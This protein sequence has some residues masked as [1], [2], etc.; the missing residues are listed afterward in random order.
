[1]SCRAFRI[2][3]PVLLVLWVGLSA[4]SGAAAADTA[5]EKIEQGA[6]DLSVFDHWSV[7][8]I[9]FRTRVYADLF[10][11]LDSVEQRV[12]REASDLRKEKTSVV[13]VGD[14]YLRI[15]EKL[16]AAE[17]SEKF[18]QVFT[19]WM[20]SE[21]YVELGQ[22]REARDAANTALKLIPSNP[23]DLAGVCKAFGGVIPLGS[24]TL[25]LSCRNNP[26]GIDF[27]PATVRIRLLAELGLVNALLGDITEAERNI[28]E[29]KKPV[30]ASGVRP[31]AEIARLQTTVPLFALGR[32]EEVASI[33][34]EIQRTSRYKQV[35]GR[36]A[37]KAN[38]SDYFDR[39]LSRGQNLWVN[40]L[41]QLASAV[42]AHLTDAQKFEVGLD[43]ASNSYLYATS[44]AR[45]GRLDE[46]KAV[47]DDMLANPEIQAMGSIYWSVAFERGQIAL[48]QGQR[49]DAIRL[50]RQSIDA[51][52]KVRSSISFEASKIGF[53]G[54]KQAVYAMLVSVLAEAGDWAGAFEVAE[55]AKAR[56]L[57]DLLAEKQDLSPPAV[58][59]EK[60]SQLLAQAV[61][62]DVLP[63][64][65]VEVAQRRDA[66]VAARDQLGKRAPE[67]ASLVSVQNVRLSDI[68]AR[69]GAG[70]T[71][72]SY[73]QA[74]DV[75]YALVVNGASVKGFK[76]AGDG[77]TSEVRRFREELQAG[78]PG[79]IQTAAGLYD[80]LLRPLSGEIKGNAVTVAPHGVLHY[81]PFAALSDGK[82]YLIDSYSLRVMP[83]ASSLVYLKADKPIKQG[84]L[85]ALGNPDLGDARFDLPSAQR[86]ALQVAAMYPSSKA[87]IRQEASK[88]AVREFGN[89]FAILHIA[90][91]GHFDSDSP[92]NSGLL[93]AK[94]R[95]ADGRL[96]VS[97][98][99]S[100]RLDTDLVTLSACETG[101]GKVASGDD[102]VGLTRGFLYAGARTIVSSLW[103]VDDE[104]TAKL[105][106]V[107]YKNL[108]RVGK[109]EALR[110]AQVEIRKTYPHP[111]FW[112]AFQVVGNG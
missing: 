87:L 84:R 68:A 76:L 6:P 16:A 1:M 57:V 36:Q 73:F 72:I 39:S 27:D 78:A 94:G 83:S 79:A 37:V 80:R 58:A 93:L 29:L 88:T 52:E 45:M 67:V 62:T 42:V 7:C 54:N 22:L 50:L 12:G 24:Q 77:L 40:L 49:E 103:Q 98:L 56:A 26:A 112:A 97:D 110:L 5:W 25:G 95:E 32:Y 28:A 109:R 18:V 104:A 14:D 91:H 89:G 99:Y 107:F 41:T 10:T 51:I 74:G 71:L 108:D 35:S 38:Q 55:R 105:M 15:A 102:V 43:G 8:G 3:G 81:L 11:C 19:N 69:L 33:Q 47:F 46:A 59:D 101:L 64:L 61:V 2:V 17:D 30:R 111:F 82:R 21:G 44:L 85:L 20:R 48:R 86:E 53:A 66:A 65:T 90:S 70:E 106:A 92:L 31:Y 9:K 96:T 100:M 60:I 13:P 63:P 34:D 4:G 23:R 75:L